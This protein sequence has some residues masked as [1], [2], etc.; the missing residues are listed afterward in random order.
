MINDKE[1]RAEDW[2]S[3]RSDGDHSE[4]EGADST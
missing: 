4:T 2:G 3:W 1:H